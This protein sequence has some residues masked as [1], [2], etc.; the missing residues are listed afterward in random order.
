[1]ALTL[2]NRNPQV[3]RFNF[4][5]DPANAGF[6]Y[7]VNRTIA[8]ADVSVILSTSAAAQ[9]F[10]VRK[11]ATACVTLNTTNTANEVVRAA[12]LDLAQ[13]YFVA[14]DT[15]NFIASNNV[16]RGVCHVAV[17]PGTTSTS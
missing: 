16:L 1:M 3:I 6:A 15:M 4:S 10:Q 17:L 12:T 13:A 14:G 5:A 11:G 2:S 9:T 8:I 7:V